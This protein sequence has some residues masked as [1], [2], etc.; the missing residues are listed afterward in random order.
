MMTKRIFTLAVAACVAPCWAA[1]GWILDDFEAAKKQAAEQNKGILIEFTGSDWCRPCM[2]LRSKVLNTDE[3]KND[4]SKDFVLLELDYP[5]RKPQTAEVKE[6]NNKLAELYKVGGYPT[7]VFADKD[8]RP[9]GFFAGNQSMNAAKDY[10]ANARK[11][12]KIIDEAEAK[13]AAATTDDERIDAMALIV[14][15][16]PKAYAETFYGAVKK[17]L[18]ELDKNDRSGL[19]DAAAVAAKAKAQLAEANEYLKAQ[20]GNNRAPENQLKA[21]REYPNRDRLL[22]QVQQELYMSEFSILVNRLD[23]VDGA[24]EVLKKA[25]ELD[26]ESSI[27]ARA[28]RIIHMLE[29]NREKIKA[30]READA[31][32]M[33]ENK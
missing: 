20:I 5:S 15:Q 22:P 4:A 28:V 2:M 25:V 19:K 23:D 21:L 8:G 9:Y 13:L 11:K 10:L 6:A 31:K 24:I 18:L 33:N 29:E 17:Q 12:K 26:P 32:R 3:F 14:K 27:G 1:D 30:Q 16:A 7:V